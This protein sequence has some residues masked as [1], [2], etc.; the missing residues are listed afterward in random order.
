MKKLFIVLTVALALTT[1]L[2]SV[3]YSWHRHPAVH[4]HY[5]WGPAAI[6]AGAWITGALILGA[7]DRRPPPPQQPTVIYVQPG[8]TVYQTPVSPPPAAPTP[9]P[10][11][12]NSTA[13]EWVTV[14][15]QWVGD[16]WVPQHTVF[17][18]Q[19]P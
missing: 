1:A 16:T 3:G 13:G 8:A 19:N 18:H 6:I 15:G 4:V 12:N 14:P 5:G 7:L 17:V 10:E 2:P 11:V 9:K